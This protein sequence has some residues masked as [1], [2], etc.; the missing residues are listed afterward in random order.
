MNTA[1]NLAQMQRMKLQGM[2]EA[3]KAQLELP[4]NEQ[5][6][7]HELLDYLLQSEVL[8][9]ENKRMDI[10]LRMAKLR[11]SAGIQNIECNASRNLSKQQLAQLADGSYR[12]QAQ[13]VL[14][15]GPT[16]CGK[17]YLA[18]ALGHQACLQGTK[19]IYLNM[20]RMIEKITLARLDGSY[21]KLI[22]YWEK[23]QLII[24]DDFGLNPLSQDMKIALLQLLEDRYGRKSIIVTSQLPVNKWYEYIDDT[25]LADAIMDRLTANSQRVELKGE[26]RRRK[27]N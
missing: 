17:S 12:Q 14:I 23:Q 8:A 26:S 18:C 27:T 3:Y 20:N 19:T 24:L 1:Q 6:D 22:N 2:Y 5:L 7:G 25:T 10:L 9:R 16:G 21:L 13:N 15:T 4:M 11:Y